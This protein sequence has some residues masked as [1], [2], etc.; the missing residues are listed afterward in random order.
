VK[1]RDAIVSTLE[2][3]TLADVSRGMPPAHRQA[4]GTLAAAGASA[5][6]S[7]QPAKALPVVGAGN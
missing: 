1:V 5:G 6:G 7:A 3:L 2:S 4:A